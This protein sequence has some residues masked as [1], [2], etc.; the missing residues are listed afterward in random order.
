MNITVNNIKFIA[1]KKV[2]LVNNKYWINAQAMKS[3]YNNMGLSSKTSFMLLKGCTLSF[4]EIEVPEGTTAQS[5]FEHTIESTGRVIT[6]TKPG[7]K[8]L[9][10]DIS[11]LSTLLESKFAN[12]S[13]EFANW[14]GEVESL[15]DLEE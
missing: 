9:S 10:W 14:G 8:R 5:P 11:E 13:L 12:S 7:I 4:D 6:F 3:M 15:E 2:F 1:P